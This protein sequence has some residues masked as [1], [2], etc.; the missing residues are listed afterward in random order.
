[1]PL[2]DTLLQD[3]E[4]FLHDAPST[5]GKSIHYGLN[6]LS[7]PLHEIPQFE[8]EV[9][10]NLGE[11]AASTDLALEEAGDSGKE[12]SEEIK[13]QRKKAQAHRNHIK[14][15]R[16]L[17]K[18]YGRTLLRN[19][20]VTTP[21]VMWSVSKPEMVTQII[22]NYRLAFLP[23]AIHMAL[24]AEEASHHH[25]RHHLDH[26]L[27]EAPNPDE[28]LGEDVM[29]VSS[30]KS[31]KG[32]MLRN[33]S[34][35][36]ETAAAVL[37]LIHNLPLTEKLLTAGFIIGGMPTLVLGF[38]SGLIVL[39]DTG[40]RMQAWKPSHRLGRLLTQNNQIA[41]MGLVFETAAS[42]SYERLQIIGECLLSIGIGRLIYRALPK[43]EAHVESIAQ[44]VADHFIAPHGL[45]EW[46]VRLALWG[47]TGYVV[48]KAARK[49]YNF[50]KSSAVVDQWRRAGHALA[51]TTV[52]ESGAPRLDRKRLKGYFTPE[53][54][55]PL[56]Y[57][58]STRFNHPYPPYNQGQ[59]A[60]YAWSALHG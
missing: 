22:N 52:L 58:L 48:E 14:A 54:K 43:P 33:Y 39:E 6:V 29:H 24:K 16:G 8:T 27:G 20:T 50:L 25:H 40:Q 41:R 3:L 60:P 47:A 10:A 42:P 15:L 5:I 11:A 17:F 59:S 30:P 23:L 21:F 53:P 31:K 56:K 18:N 13:D 51:L 12:I 4:N 57:A 1:M 44:W 37:F 32:G 34:S 35:T 9:E 26:K 55:K 28:V 19:I 2:F 45:T 7:Y 49:A 38:S 46:G 36:L